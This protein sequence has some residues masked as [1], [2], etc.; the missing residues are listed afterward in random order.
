VRVAI[1]R[2]NNPGTT[3]ETRSRQP[4]IGAVEVE[5]AKGKEGE[6]SLF[7]RSSE[8]KEQQKG[9]CEGVEPLHVTGEEFDSVSL[10]SQL[11]AVVDFWAEWCG[12]CRAI[13]PAVS[14]LAAEYEGRAV[15]AKLNTDEC[16]EILTRYRILGI[17]TLIYFK[18]GKEADRVIG[19]TGYATL[20]SRLDK[21]LD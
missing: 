7:K 13:A 3:R 5:A 16:P 10:D 15:V 9:S 11:P 18:S 21:L 4:E 12:P 1:L 14:Q 17:P 20:K 19:L 6:M 2:Q 8:P